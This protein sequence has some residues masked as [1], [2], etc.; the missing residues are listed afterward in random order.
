MT[1]LT[2]CPELTNLLLP[3][4]TEAVAKELS[5]S[6]AL[7]CTRVW[8]AWSY[9]T[10]GEDDFEDASESEMPDEIAQA[11]LRVVFDKLETIGGSK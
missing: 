5:E 7:V 1:E 9:G 2:D 6:E 3:A 10:M 11:V 4:I 8:E